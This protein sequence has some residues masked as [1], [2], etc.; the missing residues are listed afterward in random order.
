[1]YTGKRFNCDNVFVLI[2]SE[3]LGLDIM[4]K[5]SGFI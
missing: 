4:E 3:T 1:M 5:E 2:I